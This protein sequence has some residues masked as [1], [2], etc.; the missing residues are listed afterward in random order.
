MTQNRAIRLTVSAADVGQRLDVWLAAQVPD[1]SRSRIQ[2]WMGLGCVTVDGVAARKTIRTK[3]GTEIVVQIPPVQEVELAPENLP[4]RILHE[5]DDI[6]VVD[7]AAGMVVHPAVGHASGTLVNALLFHCGDSLQG[8]GGE[9]RPGIVHRLDK[10]TSGVIMVAKNERAHVRLSRQFKKRSLAKHYTA[11][12]WG[13]PLRGSGVIKTLI[14]R[15]AHDRKLMS[16][17]TKDGRE[18]VTRYEVVE[19]WEHMALLSVS[20]ET[21]RTH[22]IRVH[23][24]HIRHPVVGD[25]QYGRRRPSTPDCVTRQMLHARR[26]EFEHPSTRER[27]CLEAE[28][29][30]DMQQLLTE[31]RGQAEA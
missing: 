31:L 9:R 4:I 11:V 17:T 1:H 16:A 19:R 8:V 12:V 13:V 5:D 22:Q 18:A 24:A 26:I 29:P 6:I 28:L 25:T 15:S 3:L 21:G 20:I 27:L 10:D 14:G 23:L 30:P 2:A 7:K